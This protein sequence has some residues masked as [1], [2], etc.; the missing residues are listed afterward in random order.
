L[1]RSLL[2]RIQDRKAVYSGYPS[3][4]SK[5]EEELAARKEEDFL[6]KDKQMHFSFIAPYSHKHKK[7]KLN[8]KQ[9][10]FK[11]NK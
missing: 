9:R 8:I 10:K 7:A 6:D 5:L 2:G 11:W 3:C 4:K 1:T